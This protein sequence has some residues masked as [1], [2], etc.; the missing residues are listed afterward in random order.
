VPPGATCCTLA[1]TAVI[2]KVIAADV[3]PPGAGVMTVTAAVPPVAISADGICAVIWVALTK[4]VVRGDPF[5]F[6]TDVAT[7]SVPFAVSVNALPPG[8]T[9]VGLIEVSV[10]AGFAAGLDGDEGGDDDGGDDEGGD[11]DGGDDDGGDD[12]EDDDVLD[13]GGPELQLARP[14]TTTSRAT[15]GRVRLGSIG[16]QRKLQRELILGPVRTTIKRSNVMGITSA[17]RDAAAACFTSDRRTNIL[18]RA[19][20]R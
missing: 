12:D 13:D 10:G 8:P 5:Q 2:A 1:F 17:R 20:L 9:V 11:D 6:S 4:V 18:E 14:T 3:P 19:A 15:V 7:K 16:S